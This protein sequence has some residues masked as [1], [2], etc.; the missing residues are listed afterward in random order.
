[1][2]FLILYIRYI[3]TASINKSEALLST[4][5]NESADALILYN[6]EDQII[7]KSNLQAVKMFKYKSEEE[8][9]EN[10]EKYFNIRKGLVSKSINKKG[11]LKSELELIDNEGQKVWTEIAIKKIEDNAGKFLLMRFNDISERKKSE[12]A[13]LE[14]EKYIRS[15][16]EHAPILLFA[17]DLYGKFTLSEGKAFEIMGYKPGELVGKSSY[18]VYKGYPQIQKDMRTALTGKSFTNTVS[19]R[20]GTFRTSY[21]PLL[22]TNKHII[23]AIGVAIDIS[24]LKQAENELKLYA[25]K[26]KSSNKELEQFAYIASHDLR[27]PLRMVSNYLQLLQNRYSTDLDEDA[28]EFIHFA[29]DGAKRMN[30]LI[31]DLLEYSRVGTKEKDFNKID[32]NIIV[33]NVLSN[34]KVSIQETK[35]VIQVHNLPVIFVDVIQYTQVFQ[36]LI[37]NAL[38]YSGDKIPEIRISVVDRIQEWCFSIED[39]GIGIE[40]E[41]LEK[42]FGIFQRLHTVDKY[43][44]TGIGLA[45]V[46]KII[47]RHNGK[48]W[49]ESKIGVGSVFH[50]TI[51][52]V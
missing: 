36:N 30:V 33:N 41:Y 2:T 23:G 15:I 14:S 32:A 43:E 51:P 11:V 4:L 18:E 28:K 19:I 21:S 49:V 1:M 48:I 38:K 25:N 13:L 22:N 34:L 3:K 7:E 44:G 12:L 6:L 37:A 47:E 27:E 20:N 40:P 45:I 9:I 26:L 52:K 10:S 8:L 24:E 35:A 17:I 5:F 39:N 50:F 46:K 16:L 29:V 42:I 31:N